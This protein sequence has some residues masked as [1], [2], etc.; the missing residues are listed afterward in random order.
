MTGGPPNVSQT[1]GRLAETFILLSTKLGYPIPPGGESKYPYPLSSFDAKEV[2][3]GSVPILAWECCI[4]AN[5]LASELNLPSPFNIGDPNNPSPT[6]PPNPNL[7]G[8]SWIGTIITVGYSVL[9][10]PGI[11]AAEGAQ[12]LYPAAK[13]IYNDAAAVAGDVAK[14]LQVIA[15][16][17]VNFPRLLA[18]G[19][20]FV[21]NWSL[22][23]LFGWLGPILAWVG[24]G[25]ALA[26]GI[27][28]FVYQRVWPKAQ[29]R[30]ELYAEARSARFWNWLDDLLGTRAKTVQVWTEKSTEAGIAAAAATPVYVQSTTP[31]P[32]PP[33]LLP[34]PKG[35]AR[36]LKPEEVEA[37][38]PP[39]S[40]AGQAA[41]QP[42]AK[43]GSGSTSP[44]TTPPPDLP[45]A[46]G[47]A[48]TVTEPSQKSTESPPAATEGPM[49][50]PTPEKPAEPPAGVPTRE[51]TEAHLGSV[52][53][54]APSPEELREMAVQAE[55]ER[56]KTRVPEKTDE[57]TKKDLL[58]MAGSKEEYET[59]QQARKTVR[60]IGGRRYKA[61]PEEIRAMASVSSTPEHKAELEEAARQ[62]EELDRAKYTDK[63]HRRTYRGFM[64]GVNIDRQA[65]A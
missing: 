13:T 28:L 9:L 52:P 43:G 49:T 58:A 18:D 8:L 36:H 21:V 40:D 14:G 20:G 60:P 47:K 44:A 53:N 33:V 41:V 31:L 65:T 19:V 34:G 39:T 35:R 50:P 42:E 11:L 46:P 51:E 61:S 29:S 30:L 3:W 6:P 24:F 64:D 62:Q 26:G 57:P 63:Q 15:A 59:H 17:I 27:L 10:A 45:P 55:E 48:E 25:M 56:R 7:F 16:S 38:T 32:S 23:Q 12:A 4:F 1:A 22:G 54:R 5:G 37:E 2:D